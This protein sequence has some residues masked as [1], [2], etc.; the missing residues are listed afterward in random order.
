[1]LT[2]ASGRLWV[3]KDHLRLE[4]Q[5]T[6]GDAQIVVNGRSF[7]VSLP[8]AQTVYEGTLPASTATDTRLQEGRHD[9]HRRRDPD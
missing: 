3:A 5:S 9:P 2:G 7:W 4:L 1:M 6:N 8:A